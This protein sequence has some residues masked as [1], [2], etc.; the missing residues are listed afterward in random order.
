M[1]GDDKFAID[2]WSSSLAPRRWR[3]KRQ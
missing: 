1:G 3:N 2:R